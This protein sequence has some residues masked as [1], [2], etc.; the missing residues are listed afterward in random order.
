M[1]FRRIVIA[2][3]VAAV[4]GGAAVLGSVWFIRS[5]A[6]GRL[7]TV[8][9][10]PARPVA[11]VLG[12]QVTDA[13]PSAFLEARLELARQ[14]YAAGK[15]RAILVSGDNGQVEYNEVDPMREW[16][17]AHGVPASKVVGDYA[18]FDTYSSCVR[19]TKIFGV[20]EAIVV[21]QSF[22]LPRAVA[23][24][25]NVGVD[26]IGVGDDS[27]RVNAFWWRWGAARDKLACVKAVFDMTVDPGPRFLGPHETGIEDALRG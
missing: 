7:F 21:T 13:R 23:L 19:A 15:V 12:A 16:L 24:C 26:A 22:H 2:A 4:L 20:R 17:V 8:D 27:V 3:L 5:K 6:D 14:L 10:A 25:R 18:G 11:L 1:A 9:D